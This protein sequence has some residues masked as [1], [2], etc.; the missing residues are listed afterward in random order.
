MFNPPKLII[1]N[2][3]DFD[4]F[5]DMDTEPVTV[6]KENIPRPAHLKSNKTA[7]SLFAY[8]SE[9]F[10]DKDTTTF[11]EIE[12]MVHDHVKSDTVTYGRPY[13]TITLID[14][15]ITTRSMT[16]LTHFTR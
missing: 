7:E 9:F 3:D 5:D 2:M 14:F 1:Y 12:Q 6:L 4:D 8:A 10:K 11:T 16:I 13:V 15:P